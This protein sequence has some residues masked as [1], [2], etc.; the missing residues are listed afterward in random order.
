MKYRFFRFSAVWVVASFVAFQTACTVPSGSSGDG[1]ANDNTSNTNGNDNQTDNGNANAN[2]N[3][4]Q[5]AN[6]NTGGGTGTVSGEFSAVNGLR[7][8]MA[9]FELEVP[10]DANPSSTT[11]SMRVL[12]E[13]ELNA[14]GLPSGFGFDQ[15]IEFEPGGTTFDQPVEVKVVLATPTVL[16]TLAVLRLD[17]T[18]GAWGDSGVTATVT[19]AGTKATFELTGFSSYDAW[20]PPV[21]QGTVAIGDGEIIAGTGL[22][23]GQPFNTLPNPTTTS[24]SLTYSDFGDVF[25]LA[26]V[27]LD[28]QNPVTGDQIT[29]TA[30]LHATE[31][32][33]L[34]EGV[35]LGLV[36]PAGGLGGPSIYS[37][38]TPSFSKPVAGVMFLRKSATQWIVDVY[39]HYEGGV[40]FGQAVGDL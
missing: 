38:G 34:A 5:N 28:A 4:N 27:N 29:L 35:I 2:T 31:V 22:F 1:G 13:A 3:G 19:D 11:I 20:N 9:G 16:D 8:E 32:R 15:G 25:G 10:A 17:E 26:L 14:M 36:T 30:G 12:S 24:A 39:C 18:T 7:L 6:D 23:D 21:P 33:R 40:I 37:D